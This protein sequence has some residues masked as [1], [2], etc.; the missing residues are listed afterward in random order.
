M[1]SR[2]WLAQGALHSGAGHALRPV[3]LCQCSSYKGTP[4]PHLDRNASTIYL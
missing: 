1:Q 2:S 3:R 4:G